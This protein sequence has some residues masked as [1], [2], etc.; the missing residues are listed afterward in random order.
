MKLL[1]LLLLPVSLIAQTVK[2]D[3]TGSAKAI[4]F[5]NSLNEQQKAKAVFAFD[6]MNRYGWHYV[7]GSM[8]AR[9]G[10]AI[11]DIDSIQKMAFY[12][13]LKTFLSTE[14]YKRTQTIMSFEYLL[15]EMEPNNAHRIPENYFVSV[16]GHPGM[17]SVWA[18]KFTGHHLALNF[19]MVKNK[20]AFAPFFWG[21]NPAEVKQGAQK[22]LRVIKDEEDLG[23]ELMNSLNAEQKNMALFQS[24]AFADIVTT[25]AKE[26]SPLKPVGIPM[27]DLNNDQK[28]LVNKLIVTYLSSMSSKLANA[29][30]AML[31]TEDKNDIRFG[32]AGG[33][34]RGE[35][36]YYRLQGKTFLIEFDNTQNNANHIHMVWRDF[37][38]DYGEDLLKEHYMKSDHHH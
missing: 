34:V 8:M 15:R 26:V 25:T 20:L 10:I 1:L 17:D 28:N 27:K 37:N 4:A 19:T 14:G 23:F 6:D 32:W 11:K 38:G 30:M 36:H 16:Y 24:K 31:R 21:S 9:T 22:G 29:R 13:L 7:P 18:W 35:P 3:N 2:E 12:E 5:V 33:L